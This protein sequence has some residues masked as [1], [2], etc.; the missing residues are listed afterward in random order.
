MTTAPDRARIDVLLEQMTIEEKASLTV[1]RDFWTTRPIERLGIP[2]IWLSD[3]PTGLRRAPTSEYVGLGDSLPATCFPTES[4]LAASWDV[5]LVEEVGEALGTES[6]SLGVQILLAPG[7]NLKRSPL[8]GRNFEYFSEDPILSG[9]M[10]AALIRGVQ[11]RGVGTSLKHFAANEQETGRMYADSIVD[12]RTLRELYLRPFELAV[13]R[14]NP[15]TIM[16]AYNRLN[17]TYCTENRTLLH[18]ILKVEWGYDGIVMSDWLAINDRAAGIEAGCH[19]QMPGGPTVESVVT[20]VRSGLLEESRLDAVVRELLAVILR[21]DAARKPNTPM[22]EDAHHRLARRVAEESIV[23]LKNVDDLLPIDGDGPVE[24]AV[25]GAFARSPR[26]QGSGSSQVVPTVVENVHDELLRLAAPA[27]RLTYAPGYGEGEE[28][29]LAL[30]EEA[31]R[32]ARHAQVALV[33][34]G[35]PASYESEG[36]DRTSIDLPPAHNALVEAVL[37]VQPNVAVVLTNGSAVAMPWASRVPAIVEGWLAG[38]AGGGAL[39]EVLLG[40]VNPSGKLSETFP[41]RL[42]DTPAYLDFPGEAGRCLYGE[43]LFMGYRWYDARAIAPLFPFGHGLSYT[44]F[45]YTNLTVDKSV[46]RDTEVLTVSLTVKNTGARPGREVVQLYVHERQPRLRR[47]QKELKA[48]A[49]V[50]LRPGEEREIHFQL[51]E[52]DFAFYDPAAR[53][54]ATSSGPF[55][56]LAGSSSRDIRLQT[57]VTLESTHVPAVR[58]DRLSPIAQWMSHPLGRALLGPQL[59]AFFQRVGGESPSSDSPMMEAM[60]QELPVAKL[61]I[62][63]TM[64]ER[65]LAEMID[66]ANGGEE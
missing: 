50:S 54:W 9:E 52:R 26:Y 55:D 21:A 38:Q 28:P 46:V 39:A 14:A 36:I 11:A 48:F 37:A 24:I 49:K 63:G 44:T 16:A 18:D 22:D 53:A 30:L 19:L 45:A 41:V 65:D 23:L 35:L 4:A 40:H 8:G 58:L 60:A 42:A 12:E 15:W 17:G 31:Q 62:L 64:S 57:S 6:Q 61:P 51:S 20:A 43:G 5:D 66:A 59:D 32:V 33:F 27:M 25:L 47:P 1:G 29:D 3:G 34:V 56:L 10:A 7:A 2:S 13:A